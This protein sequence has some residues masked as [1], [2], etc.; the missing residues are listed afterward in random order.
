MKK[1]GIAISSILLVV[2]AGCATLGLCIGW[3]SI[4]AATRGDK[5][6][7]T[8]EQ[9][10][11]KYDIGYTNGASSKAELIADLESTL[12][13]NNFTIANLTQEITNLKANGSAD[14]QK[15]AIL[16]TQVAEL[17]A[18][19]A[20]LQARLDELQAGSGLVA[21]ADWQP[22]DYG[23]TFFTSKD[24]IWFDNSGN[25]YY[26]LNYRFNRSTLEWEQVFVSFPFSNFNAIYIW[27]DGQNLYYQANY[28]SG[29]IFDP[30]TLSWSQLEYPKYLALIDNGENLNPFTG[31]INTFVGSGVWK[32]NGNIYFSISN[33]KTTYILDR[34]TEFESHLAVVWK[35]IQTGDMKY[36]A[37][38]SVAKFG[39]KYFC[40]FDGYFSVFD[41]ETWEYTKLSTQR[42]SLR[43]EYFWTTNDGKVYYSNQYEQYT[44]DPVTYELKTVE[45][46]NGFIPFTAKT[47]W[48]N[49][50]N[51]YSLHGSSQYL[52]QGGGNQ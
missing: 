45:W 7:Y 22:I 39:E 2:V 36:I 20:N 28:M 47:I 26:G 42:G 46:K 17:E 15:L 21:L 40:E 24:D 23:S 12:T 25:Q 50:V 4:S 14:A 6:V 43:M 52:L 41:P 10:Q 44:F 27:S 8:E 30:E 33:S 29:C 48:T 5:L 3:P 9:A 1:F 37:G 16:Q 11:I 32:A 51:T 35:E 18:T 49:D 19:N 31:V 38:E 34:V 13:Q